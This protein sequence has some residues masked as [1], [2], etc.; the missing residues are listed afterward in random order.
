MCNLAPLV[1]TAAICA[2]NLPVDRCDA[3]NCMVKRAYDEGINAL[4]EFNGM[5]GSDSGPQCRSRKLSRS[6]HTSREGRNEYAFYLRRFAALN[7]PVAFGV[8]SQPCSES[9]AG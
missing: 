1:S 4:F 2:S 9:G 3:L 7:N 8:R 5:T 6:I